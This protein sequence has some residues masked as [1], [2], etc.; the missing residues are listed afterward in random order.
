MKKKMKMLILGL[1][2]M[3]IFAIGAGVLFLSKENKKSENNTMNAQINVEMQK[4]KLKEDAI[5]Y[6]EASLE[7][8]TLGELKKDTVVELSGMET[9]TGED[10]QTFLYV[11]TEDGKEGYVLYEKIEIVSSEAKE[12]ETEEE[13]EP[14][15]ENGKYV[16]KD[17]SLAIC[18]RTSYNKENKNDRI[19]STVLE[20]TEEQLQKI[21]T[22]ECKDSSVADLTGLEKLTALKTLRLYYGNYKKVDLKENTDLESLAIVLDGVYANSDL[23]VDV[24]KNSKLKYLEIRGSRKLNKL[25]LSQN[26]E[27]ENV[28]IQSSSISALNVSNSKNLTR[29]KLYSTDVQALDL[30]NNTRLNYI[31][32]TLNKV[33]TLNLPNTNAL[34]ELHIYEDSLTA[35]NLKSISN[36]TTASIHAPLIKTVDLS[37]NKSLTSVSIE[38]NAYV[39][40]T[41]GKSVAIPVKLPSGAKYTVKDTSIAKYA[42]GKVTG[43]KVGNTTITYEFK[44][45]KRGIDVTVDNP[46]GNSSFKDGSLYQ[47]VLNA[48]SRE[49]STPV[50]DI[51]SLSDSDLKKIKEMQCMHYH[52]IDTTGIE[53]L[54]SLEKLDLT[55]NKIES[56]NVSKN[57]KL[58]SLDLDG[59][60]I[61]KINLSKNKNLTKLSI[62]LNQ[63]TA[64]D[65]S[66]NTKLKELELSDNK[67]TSLDLSKNTNLTTVYVM[68]NDVLTSLNVSKCGNLVTLKANVN[69]LSKIDLTKNTKLT[70]LELNNN[71]ITSIDL[72]ANKALKELNLRSNQLTSIN[73][74]NNTN[75]TKLW[76]SSNALT[77]INLTSN[78]KLQKLSLQMNKF[79]F[80]TIRMIQGTNR[81]RMDGLP[82]SFAVSYKVADTKVI[83]YENNKI[84]ALNPGTTKVTMRGETAAYYPP[85]VTFKVFDIKSSTY[86]I[87]KTE[88]RIYVNTLDEAT[89]NQ[90]VRVENGTGKLSKNVYYVMDEDATVE[91]Y[92]IV[93]P[94]KKLDITKTSIAL[95]KGEQVKVGYTLNPSNT[96][97]TITWKSS[98]RKVAKVDAKGNVTGVSEGTATITAESS[99]TK[100]KDSVK[101]TVKGAPNA[102]YLNATRIKLVVGET[103]DLDTLVSS[104]TYSIIRNYKSD[105]ASVATVKSSIVKG[106]SKGTTTIRVSTYNGKTATCRVSVSEKVGDEA[107]LFPANAAILVNQEKAL[108]TT[109]P[110]KV[111]WKSSN[112][113]IATVS[114]TG[115][116]IGRKIGKTIITAT[117]TTDPEKVETAQITVIANYAKK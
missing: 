79:K 51:K 10:G 58:V 93:L 108:T 34:T 15:L 73:L 87:N 81:N 30:S 54:T 95:G 20:F 21:E 16:F 67:I 90:N 101:I 111:T 22:L 57:P 59:N 102:I 62:Y 7:S 117:S 44:G 18:V 66:N 47:C 94:V 13:A 46:S 2:L 64:I 12:E 76:L 99:I 50:E 32:V 49:T 85:D 28:D 86:T 36:L 48:Y 84:Y 4:A 9:I 41:K 89:I 107:F 106:V 98:N 80:D 69:A 72:S 27:L 97:E 71:K 37:K 29:F 39:K 113:A 40:V 55:D 3:G 75:L 8:E 42:N 43:V 103:Y 110:G 116:V 33:K 6:Q 96:N 19:P 26:T 24:T 105:N 17:K 53:K 91:K 77:T 104:G 68:G 88:K 112:K 35:V 63:L 83:K 38:I 23:Q 1:L 74:K 65:L 25:D 100:K 70:V 92:S 5:L 45:F 109:I 31:S 14:S 56:I 82:T 78:T 114:N 61:Q 52:I 60:N 115:V 11:I